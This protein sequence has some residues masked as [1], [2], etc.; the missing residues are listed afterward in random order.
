MTQKRL[1]SILPIA[2]KLYVGRKVIS[3]RCINYSYNNI[4][5]GIRLLDKIAICVDSGKNSY[6]LEHLKEVLPICDK[7]K[8]EGHHGPESLN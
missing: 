5:K 7:Y 6:K 3:V 8:Q 1:I 4:A 2:Q